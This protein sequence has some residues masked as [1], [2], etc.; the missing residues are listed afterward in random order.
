VEAIATE[1]GVSPNTVRSHVRGVLE[2]TGCT[3]QAEVIALP[4]GICRHGT[5]CRISKNLLR[6]IN[7]DEAATAAPIQVWL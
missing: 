4:S 6:L 2:K 3:R 5:V 1:G 7:F